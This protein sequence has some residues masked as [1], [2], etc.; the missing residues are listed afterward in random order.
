[1]RLTANGKRAR[2]AF[3]KFFTSASEATMPLILN[4]LLNCFIVIIYLELN[5]IFTL[6]R[7]IGD[8]GQHQG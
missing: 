1:M 8:I 4:S 2:L 6:Q 7:D 5:L 3:V